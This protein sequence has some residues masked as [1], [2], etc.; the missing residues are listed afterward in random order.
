VKG[1][2]ILF[3]GNGTAARRYLEADRSQADDYYLQGGTVLASF[4]I[5]DASGAVIAGAGLG[6]EQY[7]AWVDWTHPL[8]GEQMGTPRLPGEGRQGSPRFAEM[9]VNA[10]KSLSIAAAL[11]P[12]VSD[13]LDAAQADAVGEIR[14]WLA[15]HSVTRVGPRG[16]QEVVPVEQLQTVAVVHHTTR[17]GDPHRHVHFQI[18]T[19][20]QAAG[21]WRALDTAALFKQQG[22]IRALGTAVIA[23]HPGLAEVLDR[24]GLTL[25]PATGEVAELAP[26][27]QAMSK[28]SAQVHRNLARIEAEWQ[29]AHPGETRGRSCAHG[30]K[31]RRGRMS[32]RTRSPR[33]WAARKRGGPSLP[34]PGMTPRR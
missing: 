20:V 31:G 10:P 27:N 21:V 5:S 34:R 2:V 24:H 14:R 33:R 15:Q 26:F 22:A 4:T 11:H 32:D 6:P 18:G 9:V 23:A 29:Q 28:R 25:D 30:C 12:D 16:A 17:A 13:A 1:G 7:A 3:R 8:T 19:R